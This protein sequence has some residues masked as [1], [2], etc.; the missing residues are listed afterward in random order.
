[1]HRGRTD[2]DGVIRVEVWGLFGGV[3]RAEALGIR[4]LI[5]ECHNLTVMNVL[6]RNWKPPWEIRRIMTKTKALLQLNTSQKLKYYIIT[7]RVIKQQIFY[8]RIIV[9]LIIV[10]TTLV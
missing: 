1:M 9:I 2:E 8:L 3:K 6:K 7:E 4:K 10:S 5:I